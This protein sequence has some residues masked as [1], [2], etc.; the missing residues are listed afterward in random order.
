LYWIGSWQKCSRDRGGTGGNAPLF[1]VAISLIE[2][3]DATGAVD[4]FL[5]AGEK[6]VAF[7]TDFDFDNVARFGGG[8]HKLVTAGAFELRGVVIGVNF[9]FHGS[10]VAQK[11]GLVNT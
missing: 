5:F 4:E 6:W 1:F 2:F 3:V 10:I 8:A 9:F 7:A 11:N